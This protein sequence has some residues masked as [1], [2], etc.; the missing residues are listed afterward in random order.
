MELIA[1]LSAEHELIAAV[2]GS[3]RRF[4]S[5]S[6][7][8]EDARQYV[9]FFRKYGGSWHHEREEDLLVPALIS[10][11][12]LPADRGPIAVMLSDHARMSALLTRMSDS[13]EAGF[14]PQ[15][16][17]VA[18]LDYS[19]QL[20]AHIDMEESVFFPEAE[21]R[22]R[23]S[24]VRELAARAITEEEEAAARIGAALVAR[25]APLHDVLRGDGC[26]MCPS[27]HVT[28][29]G[30]EHEWWNEWEWEEMAE[31]VASS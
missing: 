5:T 19:E 3:L 7:T 27:F 29:S 24:G 16:Y 14:D 17:R 13:A 6:M 28:C 18:A 9:T 12:G 30:L 10:D 21:A 25:F 20:L 4:A 23:R 2:A 26:V 8:I 15:I 22:L 1:R 11:A 31:H